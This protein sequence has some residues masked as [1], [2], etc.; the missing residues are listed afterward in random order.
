M[1]DTIYVHHRLIQ[2]KSRL[3]MMSCSMQLWVIHNLTY[4]TARIL[5]INVAYNQKII[6]KTNC[7]FE[8]FFNVYYHD[9]ILASQPTKLKHKEYFPLLESSLHFWRCF[10]TTNLDKL[11]FVNKNWPFN[12]C[13]GCLKPSNL[14]QK[15]NYVK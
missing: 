15:K 8:F 14:T 1:D 7:N 11:T 5:V 10:Q 9:K 4:A 2:K 12:P 6:V 13:I 3:I